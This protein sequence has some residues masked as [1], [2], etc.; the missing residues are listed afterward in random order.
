[1]E[2]L[3]QG[4]LRNTHLPA[5][6]AMIPLYEAIVN[7]IQSIEEDGERTESALSVYEIRITILREKSLLSGEESREE[8]PIDG[9]LIQDNGS[10]FTESNWTSFKTLD[11]LYK[12]KKGCRGIGR[13]MW[14][15]AFR[16][17][18]VDSVF[19]ADRQ[20]LM[21]RRFL[22][23]PVKGVELRGAPEETSRPRVTVVSLKGFD[24]RYADQ[25][26]KELRT[27]AAGVLEHCLWYFVRAEGVPEIRIID[28][29]DNVLLGGPV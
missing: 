17:V 15:K 26:H 18:E 28:G 9:F 24:R 7:S 13:L 1:M 6:K 3:L 23:D 21:R 20:A 10:G 14:L 2:S 8:D 11:T 12:A 27:I 4:R 5:S 29:V 22:F 25:A 19:A 16:E